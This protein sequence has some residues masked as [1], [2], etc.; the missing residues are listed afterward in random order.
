MKLLEAEVR[1]QVDLTEFGKP[2]F[3]ADDDEES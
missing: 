1:G 2:E 3:L